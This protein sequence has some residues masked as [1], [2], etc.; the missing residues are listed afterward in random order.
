MRHPFPK[1][2]LLISAIV[3]LAVVLT[4]FA[5]EFMD[6]AAP[7]LL[8]LAV[9]VIGIPHGA[10]DHVVAADLFGLRDRLVDHLRFYSIYLVIMLM[11][12]LLWIFLPFAGMILF[13]VISIY[14]FGQADREDLLRQDARLAPVFAW[15]RGLMVLAVI[16][17]AWPE[18]CIPI[19]EAAVRARPDWFDVLYARAGTITW[20]SIGQYLLISS[21]FMAGR[22]VVSP[23]KL[24]GDSLLLIGLLL[25]THPLIG[26]AIYFALWHSLGHVREMMNFF[27]DKGREVTILK[28]Y[29]LALP[30]T[31]VSLTG[32]AILFGI[33]RAFSFGDEMLSLL[34]I[35]ISVLTLP[36]V[37]LVDRMFARRK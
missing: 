7:W 37:L 24:A 36:H 22:Q 10:V 32:L 20:I 8:F 21:A 29:K 3:L 13:L 2:N 26:F 1:L 15:S 6:A 18:I 27:R 31:L 16:V 30:F 23:V 33:H 4:L 34:F 11:I 14:H 17:F 35:L 19:I 5:P 9:F 25:L 12:G 28:F